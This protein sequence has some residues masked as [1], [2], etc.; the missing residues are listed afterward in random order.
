MIT[1]FPD[2]SS[3]MRSAMARAMTALAFGVALTSATVAQAPPTPS[4]VD[5]KLAVR[6]VVGGLIAP[7]TMAF[8]GANEFLVL[9]K[10]SG[11]VLHVT[12]GAVD[13]TSIDLAVNNASERGLLG[14]A[15][16]PQF[17]SNHYVY[18]YWTCTAAPPPADN[19]YF[20]TVTECPD[21]PMPGP[22]ATDIL[23]VPLLGNRVD[24]FVY[25]S[26]TKSLT[27]DMNLVKIR[28][29]QHDGAPVPAGQGDAAQPA[30]G[31]HNGGVI[32][33]GSD[34]KLYII[35]G[36][37]GRR[38]QM[39]NLPSGPTPTG[40][41]TPV[42]DDQFG[43]PQPD[44]AHLTGVILRL[45]RDGSAPTDNPFY[46]TGSSIGGEVGA[47]L[48]KVYAYGIR[49]S[50]GMAVDPQSGNLWEQEN[51]DDSFDELNLVE[52]GMNSG[53]IQTMGPVSRVAQFKAIETDTAFFGLQQL[54][55][56]PV[57]I[58]NTP[59]EALS[60]MFMLPGAK[61][62]DPE[63]SWKYAVAPAAIG[64]MSGR[65]IGSQ[66]NGDLFVGMSVPVP[67]GG[68]L[69]RFDLTGNRS[70]IAVDGAALADRVDDNLTKR[71]FNESAS[72]IFGRN[73]GVVTDIE[74]GPNGNL[75]VVSLTHGKVYEIYDVQE[76][77]PASSHSNRSLR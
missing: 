32:T 2:F 56:S 6:E 15:L 38:G 71:T 66:Y 76:N 37:N 33:F 11:K 59:A 53:W 3:A 9:E 13:A 19:P 60:R 50:F 65:G 10:A 25:S 67:D 58:A 64:F 69:M 41:G 7:T 51:G 24:R 63:F 55:W 49:N 45:N 30:R 12:N 72:L 75:Y 52:K 68:V 34:G 5:T 42:A 27:W 18:L 1:T 40:G 20:P 43:G 14:I 16:D 73:F 74:T 17:A 29:F 70:R 46:S 28:S 48:R 26:A 23:A 21:Q 8:V 35:I 62:S 61:F 47:N 44:R 31:N 54:R 39:Q 77:S 57:N 22:D 4:V 36:D